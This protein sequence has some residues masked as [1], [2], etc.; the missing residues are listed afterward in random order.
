VGLVALIFA[1]D[2]LVRRAHGIVAT[3]ALDE[4]AHLATAGLVLLAVSGNG[5]HKLRRAEAL[6]V[7]A[8]AV[9]IDLDHIPLYAGLPQV[10]LGGRPFS[11]SLLTVALLLL[12]SA[13]LPVRSRRWALAA[14]CGVALHFVRDIATGPGLLLFWPVSDREVLLPYL[15]YAAVVLCAGAVATARSLVSAARREASRR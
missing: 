12:L 7:L 11:H 5:R 2:A 9:L 14:A 8:S 15:L 13:V 4:P 10:A 6:V 1:C 3:G